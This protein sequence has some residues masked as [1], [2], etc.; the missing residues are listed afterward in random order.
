MYLQLL[1]T[2]YPEYAILLLVDW[3]YPHVLYHSFVEFDW[4]HLTSQGTS[5]VISV[6]FARYVWC[7][8]RK[9]LKVALQLHDDHRWP[10]GPPDSTAVFGF[11]CEDVAVS[12]GHG[13]D[14]DIFDITNRLNRSWPTLDTLQKRFAAGEVHIL[15]EIQVRRLP[16][17]GCCRRKYRIKWGTWSC[18]Y[19]SSHGFK[20]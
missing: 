3:V 5:R 6:R 10:P 1:H 12:R 2:W 4:H 19:P 20:T 15:Q 9:G 7:F 18:D 14:L 16:I 8:P 13:H 11:H 17:Q